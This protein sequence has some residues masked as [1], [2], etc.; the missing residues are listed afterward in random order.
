MQKPLL[1]LFRKV[2]VL[3]RCPSLASSVVE[4]TFIVQQV[5]QIVTGLHKPSSLARSLRC[6]TIKHTTP[7]SIQVNKLSNTIASCTSEPLAFSDR[8]GKHSKI[9]DNEFLE[10]QIYKKM[11][12]AA[13]N[14]GLGTDLADIRTNDF[15][16]QFQLIRQAC[17]GVC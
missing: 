8:N 14:T 6:G 12:L 9:L 3:F 11:H 16:C 10:L 17:F 4:N 15:R 1:A 13:V 2:R 5:V 7:V